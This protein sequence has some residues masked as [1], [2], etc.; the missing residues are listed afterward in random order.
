MEFR[1]GYKLIVGVDYGTTSTGMVKWVHFLFCHTKLNIAQIGVSYAL[2]GNNQHIEIVQ[3]ANWPPNCS[4]WKAPS[5]VTYAGSHGQSLWGFEIRPGMQ[6][7]SW[8]KLLLDPTLDRDDFKVETLEVASALGILKLPEDR[9]AEEVVTD[10][11]RHV[12]LHVYDLLMKNLPRAMMSLDSVPIEFW[13]TFPA[14]WSEVAQSRLIRAASNAG[15]G[16]RNSDRIFTV[17]EPEAAA[18]AVLHLSDEFKLKV[19]WSA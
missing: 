10:F 9:N 11:L 17:S 8:T 13:V 4:G 14:T 18:L 12:Y 19:S 15:F 3:I 5:Q 16:S 2:T 6:T 1:N 7:F